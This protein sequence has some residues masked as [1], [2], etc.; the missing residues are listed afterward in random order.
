MVISGLG[1]GFNELIA[2]AG[3]SELVPVKKR[4]VY[5]ASVV[6]TIL[7][8][9][10]STM[11]AQLI[12]KDSTWRWIGMLVGVWNLVGLVLVA[13]CYKDPARNNRRRPRKEILREIDY[14]GGLFSTVGALLFMM[15]MQWGANQVSSHDRRS[16][17]ITDNLVHLD[18]LTRS[19]AFL[20]WHRLH[21]CVLRLGVLRALPHGPSTALRTG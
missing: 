15:G 13:T 21:H 20:H 17:R 16:L 14:L 5:V 11:W 10:P 9:C 2:L 4:G 8:F 6:F 12:A 18:I 19:C 7:P 1:A 3:T